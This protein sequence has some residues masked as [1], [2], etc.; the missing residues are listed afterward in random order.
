MAPGWNAVPDER[1]LAAARPEPAAFDAFYR[2]HENRVLGY[3]T[4]DP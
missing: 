4:L 3:E 1:L 2:R